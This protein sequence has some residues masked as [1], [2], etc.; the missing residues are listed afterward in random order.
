M[1]H[2]PISRFSTTSSPGQTPSN[3]I[4]ILG[5]FLIIVIATYALRVLLWTYF[6]P[7]AI[8]P[9]ETDIG[10]VVGRAGRQHL[11]V[12]QE[13]DFSGGG[14]FFYT[15]NDRTGEIEEAGDRYELYELRKPSVAE[16][17]EDEEGEAYTEDTEGDEHA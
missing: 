10:I 9:N 7:D 14:E 6:P 12:R 15:S 17:D 2:S 1:S 13:R 3:P 4:R 8:I 5:I 16:E 11:R